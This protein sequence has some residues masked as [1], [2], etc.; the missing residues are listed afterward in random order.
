ML[1]RLQQYQKEHNG[2]CNV[3][4]RYPQ[5]PRLG[6]WVSKQRYN[7]KKGSLAKERCDQLEAIGFEWTRNRGQQPMND[8]WT[9]MFIRLQAYQQERNGSCNVS[10]GYRQDPALGN[11]VLKQR[12]HYNKAMLT[13][14][15]FDQLEKIGFEWKL[16]GARASTQSQP[17]LSN[18]KAEQTETREPPLRWSWI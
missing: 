9:K 4:T 3:P 18:S 16:I 6:Q 8:Q 17:P 14:E 11:W 15:R 2:S 10:Q 12:Y 7:Y 13:K 5:D 1:K